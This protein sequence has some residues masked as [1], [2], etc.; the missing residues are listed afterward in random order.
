MRQQRYT[1]AGAH[2]ADDGHDVRGFLPYTGLEACR[3]AGAENLPV[4]RGAVRRKDHH[5]LIGQ[6]DERDPGPGRETVCIRD[7]SHQG[8]AGHCLG[9]HC[10]VGHW[11]TQQSNVEATI[12]D[13]AQ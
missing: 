10:G 1:Q 11:R 5:G 9:E 12:C 8:L 3:Q 13:G 2:E 6:V 4:Q 7:R